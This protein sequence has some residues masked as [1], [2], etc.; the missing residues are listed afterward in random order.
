MSQ[1]LPKPHEHYRG[2]VKAELDLSNYLTKTDLKGALSVNISNLAAIP[3]LVR[4]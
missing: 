2:N 3:D 1:Y 4:N